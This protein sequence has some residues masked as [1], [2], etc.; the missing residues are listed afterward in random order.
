MSEARR[1]VHPRDAA[2]L[3]GTELFATDW[4]RV[5]RSHL[6]M[7]HWSVDEVAAAADVSANA[8]FPRAADNV[9]GFMLVALATSAFFNNFPIGG[10][11]LVAWNY[12]LDRVR[13]PATVYL[14]NRIRLR[15]TLEA[16]EE[17]GDGW[18]LRNFVTIDLE[19]S[20]RP[21]MVGAWLVMLTPTTG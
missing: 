3:V 14:E 9:D 7:F 16:V 13:F 15:T 12:G 19:E 11:G 8:D 20:T 17:R 4:R 2:P 10:V 18:L 21:A 6:D 1:T 5:D